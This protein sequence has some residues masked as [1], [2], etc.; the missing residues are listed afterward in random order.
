MIK[1][2]IFDVDGTL[3]DSMGMWDHAAERYLIS[4]NI[5]PKPGLEK[6]MFTFTM[7]NAGKYLKKTYKLPFD[8]E[9]IIDG[10]NNTIESFYKY[11]AQPKKGVINFLDKLY[12]EKIPMTIAT[13]TD[14]CHI[15]A[16]LKRLDMDKYFKK[17]FT[18]SEVGIGKVKPDIYIK[19]S[20]FMGS[21]INETWVFEDAYHAAKTAY[22]AGF[23]VA[24]LFDTSSAVHLD[25]LKA[26]CH[27]YAK[28]MEELDLKS[29]EVCYIENG[30]YNSGK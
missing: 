18:C 7:Q 20:E 11:E 5:T 1:G 28:S 17:I 23:R 2:A 29:G 21:S 10:I 9:E 24:G 15:E 8:E 25:E 14:R 12:N 30:S 26:N 27:I 22:N 19:A 6:K 4:L 3:L 16:A 13:S